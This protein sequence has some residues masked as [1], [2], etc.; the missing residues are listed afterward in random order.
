MRTMAGREWVVVR[1]SEEDVDRKESLWRW[2]RA[3][4]SDG[5]RRWRRQ[6]GSRLG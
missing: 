6:A 4:V 5:L 1:W 2:L 3:C